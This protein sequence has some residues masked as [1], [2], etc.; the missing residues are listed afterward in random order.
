MGKRQW[1]GREISGVTKLWGF[2]LFLVLV[3]SCSATSQHEA[4]TNAIPFLSSD[5][6]AIK[7][8]HQDKG[9][10]DNPTAAE[11]LIARMRTIQGNNSCPLTPDE[12]RQK[13]K[14]DTYCLPTVNG[15]QPD[16]YILIHLLRWSD[17]SKADKPKSEADHWYLY[18]DVPAGKWSQ[19]D[20]TT[21]KRTFGIKR[22]YVLLVQLNA[23]KFMIGNS[24]PYT[25]GYTPNY[26]FTITKKTPANVGHLYALLQAYTGGA[27]AGQGTG[28]AA[29][30]DTKALP[31]RPDAVWGG[32][33]LNIQ[34]RPSDIL[35][36]STF[37]AKGDDS[38]QKL[39]D[40]ITFDN[41]GL[42]HWDVGFAVPVRKISE[43]KLDTTSGTATPAKVNSENV[44]AILDGYIWPIDVKGS[45]F[46]AI[47]HPIAGVAFA[48]QPL[49]KI[50]VG[51][52]WGPKASELYMGAMF[53]KQP[54]LSGNSSCS[55]PSGTSL[56]GKSHFCA[57]FT[58]GINL[59]VSAI[60]SKLGAPK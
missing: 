20:F 54:E 41:E 59:S 57:Q 33:I 23:G 9:T 15:N 56:T 35:I 29:P 6:N 51:G 60:A 17:S 31:P 13:S 58:I 25:A 30:K 43:L 50:L 3:S 22:A 52:A 18:R 8:L 44:F 48:K 36:K 19:E 26:D 21:A 32:G 24:P 14:R 47:P 5:L 28:Q 11:E 12:I 49:H 55:N 38:D 40:D 2:V 34:Y 39:A 42:Y 45:G 10:L 53:V 1:S 37:R 7:G 46:N 4:F 27:S 16:N